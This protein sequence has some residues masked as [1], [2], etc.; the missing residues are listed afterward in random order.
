[1]TELKSHNLI[2]LSSLADAIKLPFEVMQI[3]V[4]A[5]LCAYVYYNL[6]ILTARSY[7]YQDIKIIS[8]FNLKEN[9]KH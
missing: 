6:F 8:Y 3:C 1:M 2:V 9:L 7:T 5:N 4:T